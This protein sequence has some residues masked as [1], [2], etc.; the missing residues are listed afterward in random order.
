LFATIGLFPRDNPA[1]DLGVRAYLVWPRFE[2][3]VWFGPV[4]EVLGNIVY[5]A[6]ALSLILRYVRGDDRIRRQP[7]NTADERDH[8]RILPRP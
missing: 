7:L 3:F 2:A 6:A 8:T 1:G 4:T 5:G